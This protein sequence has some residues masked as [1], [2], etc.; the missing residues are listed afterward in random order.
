MYNM[1]EN[2]NQKN[3]SGQEIKENIINNLRNINSKEE[4]IEFI[5]QILKNYENRRQ[6]GKTTKR[7]RKRNRKTKN[8][9]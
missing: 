7:K 4:I 5:K 8:K 2:S 3:D 1:V 9:N 6:G